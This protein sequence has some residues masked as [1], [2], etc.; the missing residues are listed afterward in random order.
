LLTSQIELAKGRGDSSAELAFTV[1]LG[2]VFESRLG[3]AAKAIET[4]EA[5]LARDPGHRGALEAL[6]RLFE[7]KGELARAAEA[8]EKLL[9]MSSGADA[10]ATAL[11]L[12]DVFAKLKD[13]EGVRRVLER[14]LAADPA[15]ADIRS[16]LATLYER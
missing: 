11:R 14:G 8:L 3:N 2:E 7:K 16:R 12:S 4:Y 13:D 5:V 1:R 15:A 9:G 10:V 6:A